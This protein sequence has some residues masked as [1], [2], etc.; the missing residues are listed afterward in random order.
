MPFLIFVMMMV[1][2]FGEALD[3]ALLP[4]EPGIEM[5]TVIAGFTLVGIWVQTNRGRLEEPDQ[6]VYKIILIKPNS[7]PDESDH[8]RATFDDAGGAIESQAI[9]S[10]PRGER[11]S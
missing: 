1:A 8:T 7:P 3:H 9:Q 6:S 11:K 10:I 4:I 5:F 2:L